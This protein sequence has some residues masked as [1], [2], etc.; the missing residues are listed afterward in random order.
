MQPVSP[1]GSKRDNNATLLE[2]LV[3]RVK[4]EP[5]TNKV[6]VANNLPE[7]HCLRVINSRFQSFK[8]NAKVEYRFLYIGIALN[9]K[10]VLIKMTAFSN[11]FEKYVTNYSINQFIV[12]FNCLG[13]L[14]QV[15]PLPF[16]K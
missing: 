3:K 11:N 5:P 4:K 2:E 16:Q 8:V 12:G 13:I 6:D 10:D 14:K 9:D 1:T 15:L 7:R